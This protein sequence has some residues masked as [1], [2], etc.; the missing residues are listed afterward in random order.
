MR[1]DGRS[2]AEPHPK[3]RVHE[4]TTACSWSRWFDELSIVPIGGLANQENVPNSTQANKVANWHT[5][6]VLESL[7]VLLE[8][9]CTAQGH[10]DA[11]A[12]RTQRRHELI[13]MRLRD[14]HHYD[15]VN[16]R[17]YNQIFTNTINNHKH[18]VG[19]EQPWY[20]FERARDIQA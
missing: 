6:E 3:A 10:I 5:L 13:N 16:S 17:K 1:S 15:F 12:R 8:Y 2:L 14:T 7:N 4:R 9:R 20:R 11:L 18:A 19:V